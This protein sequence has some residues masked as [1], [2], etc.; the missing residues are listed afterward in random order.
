MLEIRWKPDRGLKTPVY[1]QIVTY[2]TGRI[3]S[4]EWSAGAVIPTQR[5]LAVLFGVNRST[6]ITEL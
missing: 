5:E 3:L 2:I 6:V 4:G 1:E